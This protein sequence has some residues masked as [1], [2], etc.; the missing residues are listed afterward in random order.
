MSEQIPKNVVP[1]LKCGGPIRHI[2]GKPYAC[3]DCGGRI[4]YNVRGGRG[5]R[6][7]PGCHWEIHNEWLVDVITTGED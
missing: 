2:D 7:A 5:E 4:L 1:C 6:P 3:A